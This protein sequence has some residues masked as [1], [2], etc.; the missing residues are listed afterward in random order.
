MYLPDFIAIKVTLSHR[1]SLTRIAHAEFYASGFIQEDEDEE[2]EEEEEDAEEEEA[3]E[4]GGEGIAQP[5]QFLHVCSDN[6]LERDSCHTQ[7]SA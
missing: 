1:S 7:G 6:Q 2:E 3:E 4:T 5:L